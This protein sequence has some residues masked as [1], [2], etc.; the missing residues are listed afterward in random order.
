MKNLSTL[1]L[2][3]FASVLS[4]G[5]HNN[6]FYNDGALIHLD[7][8]AEIHVWGDVHM[9][10]STGVLDNNGLIKTQ[11]H[12]YSDANFQQIGTGTYRIENSDVNIGERQSING[13][14]AVRGGQ[15]SIGVDDGSFYNLE[16]ANDQ[17]IVFLGTNGVVADVRNN[18]DFFAGTVHNRIITNAIPVTGALSYPANG[19]SYNAVFGVMNPSSSGMT[20]S[21]VALYGNMSSV[22]AGYVQG[23]LRR[24]IDPSGGTYGFEVGLEP[25]GAG[26]QR[27]IQYI[28]LNFTGANNYDVMYSYFQTASPNVVAGT[29]IEC[30]GNEITYFGGA[31][32][33]EWFFQ[34]QTGSGTGNYGVTVYPQDDNF[35]T[36]PMWVITNNDQLTGTPNMCGLT[37]VGLQ[38]T[39]YNTGVASFTVAA[40]ITLL[41]AEFV[42]I[43]AAGVGDHIDV[44]WKVASETNLS[45]YEIERS[46]DGVN[47]EYIASLNAV[48]NTTNSVDYNY[49]DF[50]VRPNQNYYYQVKS[51]DLDGSFEYT[52][53]VMATIQA[54]YAGFDENAVSIFPNPTVSDFMMSIVS[55]DEKD[56]AISIYNP[57]GQTMSKETRHI[58]AGNTVLKF[59]LEEKATGIYLIEIKDTYSN[60][61]ITKRILKK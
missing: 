41:S 24:A 16:L 33:G 22:D 58:T 44:S 57:L 5:Q 10:G 11:G 1:P 25:A 34:D 39:G 47:F 42:D 54:Q 3:L 59:S 43:N 21:V 15:A 19:A 32:H 60:Q 6:E 61:T 23:H 31:D 36:A 28:Q 13:S 4:F 52:P 49:S 17:G 51:V 20:N 12:S 7:P 50:D 27:G 2:F 53:I 37:P 48:G 18:V 9:Y 14:F 8:G 46:K 30:S 55:A 45:H 38:R 26:A 56:I 29:P 40:P 35:I